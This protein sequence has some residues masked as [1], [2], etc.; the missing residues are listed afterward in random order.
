[1]SE[2]RLR[3]AQRKKRARAKFWDSHG[4]KIRLAL[5]AAGMVVAAS[6]VAR[7]ALGG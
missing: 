4:E 7:A 5:I 1:M 3:T 6:L 2:R